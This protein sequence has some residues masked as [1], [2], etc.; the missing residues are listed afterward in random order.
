MTGKVPVLVERG[1]DGKDD[2]AAVYESLICNE[3]LEDA[4]PEPALMPADPAG[5]AA[6]RI[7]MDRFNSRCMPQFYR[8]LVRQVLCQPEELL[9][10]SGCRALQ[11]ANRKVNRLHSRCLPQFYRLLIRQVCPR[12]AQPHR[13]HGDLISRG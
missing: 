8:M 3:Y 12:P 7:V 5:R 13:A 2:T 4:F 11:L 9:L 6:A 10:R 1:D